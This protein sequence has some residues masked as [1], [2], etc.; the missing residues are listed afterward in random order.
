MKPGLPRRTA[1]RV[2]WSDNAVRSPV[3]FPRQR[4]ESLKAKR[5][6]PV[7]YFA[8]LTDGASNSPESGNQQ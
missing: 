1:D 4:L 6:S 2:D 3:V 5:L 7:A 8:S